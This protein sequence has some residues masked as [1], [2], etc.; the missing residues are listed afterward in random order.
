MESTE[1][2]KMD[3]GLPIL[4]ERINSEH[5]A[6]ISAARKGFMHAIEAGR[7]LTEA[8]V[9]C[10]HGQWQKWLEDNFRGSVRG[11][12]AYMRLHAH[13]DELGSNAQT[14]AL[15]TCEA[16][17]KMIAT[18]RPEPLPTFLP[19][20]GNAAQVAVSGR[21]VYIHPHVMPGYFFCGL[22]DLESGTVEYCRR[23]V[24][25]AGV[26]LM[27]DRL[28]INGDA[29][30]WIIKPADVWDYDHFAYE[31]AEE[32]QQDV[33]SHLVGRADNDNL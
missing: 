32:A 24:S 3:D 5:D 19:P 28:G 10:A 1:L 20:P 23:G 4:A 29:V 26:G 7:L 25:S 17:L 22:A 9:L 11:A 6:A 21:L 30:D 27:L 15:L 12:Q 13:R 14:P 2:A 31:T 18:P 33:S 16:A 8:K